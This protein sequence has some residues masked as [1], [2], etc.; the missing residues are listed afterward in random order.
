MTRYGLTCAQCSC[1]A[2]A[3]RE[4]VAR[5]S[6]ARQGGSC[7]IWLW[8]APVRCQAPN[9][10]RQCLALTDI[11]VMKCR[12]AAACACRKGD[13]KERHLAEHELASAG[14]QS[15]IPA[16]ARVCQVFQ[17]Q[18]PDQAGAVVALHQPCTSI[19]DL[20]SITGLVNT[21]SMEQHTYAIHN[22]KASLA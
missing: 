16:C 18:A 3:P 2:A 9:L 13:D 7:L 21:A 10:L 19:N 17:Q 15:S 11:R 14:C 22:K 20:L 8:G 1:R 6:C 12:G 5:P 4:D